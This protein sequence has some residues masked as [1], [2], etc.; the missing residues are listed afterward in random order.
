MFADHAYEALRYGPLSPSAARQSYFDVSEP[1]NL[2]LRVESA[3]WG[4]NQRSTPYDRLDWIETR[5]QL[6]GIARQTSHDLHDYFARRSEIV[7]EQFRRRS[8]LPPIPPPVFNQHGGFVD[9]G[10]VATIQTESPSTIYYTIDGTDPRIPGSTGGRDSTPLVQEGARKKAFMPEDD[11]FSE[12][13]FLTD[14]DDTSWASGR[15][16]AGYENGNGYEDFLDSGLDFADQV[17]SSAHESLYMRIDFDVNDPTAF[18]GMTLKMRYDDGFIAYLNGTEIARANSRGNEGTLQAWNASAASTHSDAEATSFIPFD[19][20]DSI[21]HLQ[22]GNNILAVHGLNTGQSSSDFLIWPTLEAYQSQGGSPSGMQDSAIRYTGGIQILEPTSIKARVKSGS[23]WSP[24]LQAAFLPNTSLPTPESVTI[25][26]IHYRPAALSSAERTAGV[27]DRNDFEFLEIRNLGDQHIL[28]S[29][30]H[31][32]DG[33]R[34]AFSGSL[35][36]LSPQESLIIAADPEIFSLRSRSDLPVF[37]PFRF[38]SRLAN[39]GERITLVSASGEEIFSVRYNDASPWPKQ[40]DGAG[41]ALALRQPDTTIDLN[42]P[43]SWV[44]QAQDPTSQDIPSS[45]LVHSWFEAN[46]TAVD[47]AN[48]L[49]SG[50]DADPDEDKIANL[51]EFFFGTSPW[52]PSSHENDLQ[53]VDLSAEENRLLSFEFVRRHP[54]PTGMWQLES[55]TNL[56]DWEPIVT[57]ATERDLSPT[58]RAV[59]LKVSTSADKT[60][61]RLAI[62]APN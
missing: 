57:E 29:G 56:V 22:S 14:F 45:D 6:F 35:P 21:Q 39:N 27:Q 59:Q 51:R 7:L 23:N 38:G 9:S 8:W 16:G 15:R 37:G 2:P 33:I 34:F 11:R 24:L 31:F 4:D 10:F 42:D 43:Q 48:P 18:D 5:N 41:F 36:Q 47:L 12:T 62:T 55:S 61:F 30:A 53:L 19:V 40:A 60:F 13:W 44:A 32:S 3:R 54:I 49:V 25:S 50:F 1:I 26:R 58:Q 17:S 28:L 46:F 52:E 20:S